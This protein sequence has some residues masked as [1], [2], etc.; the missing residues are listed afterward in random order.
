MYLILYAPYIDWNPLDGSATLAKG[1]YVISCHLSKLPKPIKRY[2]SLTNDSRVKQKAIIESEYLDNSHIQW[3]TTEDLIS[4]D[5]NLY[6][7]HITSSPPF[8]EFY[9]QNTL[10]N[11]GGNLSNFGESIISWVKKCHDI[12]N[13]KDKWALN[14]HL[15]LCY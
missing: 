11:R 10:N 1:V 12:S 8:I 14:I 4:T 3:L 2:E 7:P 6:S 5:T 15:W 9:L 13:I